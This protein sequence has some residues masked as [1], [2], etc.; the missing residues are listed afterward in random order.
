MTVVQSSDQE[1]SVH[2]FPH[3]P[4]VEPK[5]HTGRCGPGC[6]ATSWGLRPSPVSVSAAVSW[7]THLRRGGSVTLLTVLQRVLVVLLRL[8]IFG[9]SRRS[10]WSR[11][12]RG[13]RPHVSG[14]ADFDRWLQGSWGVCA[15]K[16]QFF[17]SSLRSN[18][19][20]DSWSVPELRMSARSADTRVPPACWPS[21]PGSCRAEALTHQRHS[22][23]PVWPRAS[24]SSSCSLFRTCGLCVVVREAAS[25]PRDFA[26]PLDPSAVDAAQPAR[27]PRWRPACWARWSGSAESGAVSCCPALV[28]PRI[29]CRVFTFIFH[30]LFHLSPFVL[31]F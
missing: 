15:V 16:L 3:C 6:A 13:A 1:T 25:L 20:H 14:G 27:P 9:G 10:P 30:F 29:A 19:R 18:L 21:E 5:Q 24:S 7:P 11:R 4:Q 28:M 26:R 31:T 8:C 23:G 2:N 22:H 12:H 17:H